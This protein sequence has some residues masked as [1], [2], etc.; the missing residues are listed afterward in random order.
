[1]DVLRLPRLLAGRASDAFDASV[2][3]RSAACGATLWRASAPHFSTPWSAEKL[4]RSHAEPVRQVCERPD[5]TVLCAGLYRL[6][7]PQRDTDLARELV[8][9]EP[10]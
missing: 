1:M 9:G 10:A 7:V 5:G 2:D 6:Q 4:S 3:A 8:L